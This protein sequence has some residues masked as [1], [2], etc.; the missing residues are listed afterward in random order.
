MSAQDTIATPAPAP[1]NGAV[2]PAA[3]IPVGAVPVPGAMLAGNPMMPGAPMMQQPTASLY[4]GEL[5][6]SVNEAFLFEMFNVIGPVASVRV[7][8]D[9]VTRRS[10]GYAYV[11]FHNQVDGERALE[12]LNYTPIKGRVCRIMWSQRDPSVRRTGNGNIFIK[13]LDTSIDNKAL[14]DTFVAFGKIL[15]CKVAA[16]D[17]QSLGYGFVHYETREAAE[18]AIAAVNGMLLNDKE[19]FVGFH[20]PRRERDVET[21]VTRSKFTNLYVKDVAESITDDEFSA[22]FAA[23]GN[24]VSAVV[25]RNE[26]GTSKGFGFVNYSTHEEA[27]AALDALHGTDQQGKTLFITRA[28]KKS[29]RE[30]ELRRQYEAARQE[31]VQKYQGSNVYVKFLDDDVDDD[32]LR[33]EFAQFGTITSA[34]VMCDEKGASRGFGFV[35]FATPDEAA[36]AV[37]EMNGKMLGAKPLYVSLAQR[38]DQRRAQLEA[39]HAH[40]MQMPYRMAPGPML[41]PGA[42]PYPGYYPAPGAMGRPPF[43]P[44]QGPM[45]PGGPQGGPRTRWPAPGAPGAPLPPGAIPYPMTYPP[46]AGP[47]PGGPGMPG[48][49]G[50]PM[51]P[52]QNM[53]GGRGGARGGMMR[54][55]GQPRGGHRGQFHQG[56]PTHAGQQQGFKY[57][58]A[59]RNAPEDAAAA[60]ADA[61]AAA[62]AP[63]P[64]AAVSALPASLAPGALAAASPEHQKQL[65]GEALFPLIYALEAE[66]A[67]KITGMLLEMEVTEVLNLIESPA[68]LAGKVSEAADLVRQHMAADEA[69]EGQQQDE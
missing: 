23:H 11:N 52:Q 5:D 2:I 21:T 1:V 55:A 59:A 32:K 19:V 39:N 40:R 46:M 61:A 14:H 24:V 62:A 18:A 16:K 45:G 35:C 27:Q 29:E 33:N 66:H 57:T 44:P 42:M 63:A 60:V 6:L 28:Q 53:R 26:D 47:V 38:K 37:A 22:L 31:R 7:C 10:L 58:S 54:G 36:A 65:L 17:G 67:P 4:V 64:T 30:E 8:R 20:V 49:P 51:V 48:A 69:A 15:S 34:K 25:S 12:Q 56:G 41:P 9:A 68:D 43:F 3:A 13:N 50:M